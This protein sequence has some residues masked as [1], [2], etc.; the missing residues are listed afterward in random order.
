MNGV[1]IQTSTMTIDQN[2]AVLVLNHLTSG[3][4]RYSCDEIVD[5]PP[6]VREDVLPKQSGITGA[7]II[8]MSSRV[9]KTPPPLNRV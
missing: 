1:H 6:V 5:H 7:I 4:P 2:P 9:T 3:K 8:G